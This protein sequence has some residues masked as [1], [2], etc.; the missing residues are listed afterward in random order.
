MQIDD[1][2]PDGAVLIPLYR[3]SKGIVGY[4]LVDGADADFVNQWRWRL[5]I[6]GYAVRSIKTDRGWREVLLH[7]ELLGLPRV[8]DGRE[9][10]HQDRNRLNC[11]RRNLRA[12]PHVSNPQNVSSHRDS[13]SRHRGVSWDRSREKWTVRVLANGKYHYFGRFSDEAEAAEVA[14]A[15]RTR[16]MPYAL[17]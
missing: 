6:G 2:A 9:G 1:T 16:L 17:E 5:H 7:R 4:V 11:R 15:A 12:I 13:T 8:S 10:D 14:R 3:R